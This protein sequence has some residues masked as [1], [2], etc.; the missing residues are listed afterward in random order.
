[1]SGILQRFKRHP[2]K[3]PNLQR[4]THCICRLGSVTC[5]T[6]QGKLHNCITMSNTMQFNIRFRIKSH[7]SNSR[8]PLSV[9]LVMCAY[10]CTYL[11]RQPSLFPTLSVSTSPYISLCLSLSLAVSAT[12]FLL[13][14]RRHQSPTPQRPNNPA[15]GLPGGDTPP[16]TLSNHNMSIL[17]K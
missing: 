14:T 16:L 10:I 1:M 13:R 17:K 4:C 9:Y 7:V 8:G 2:K 3:K 11:P 6:A 5:A 12:K 15:I